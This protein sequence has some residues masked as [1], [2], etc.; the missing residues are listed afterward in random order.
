V[1][2][3]TQDLNILKYLSVSHRRFNKSEGEIMVHAYKR[4]C[5]SLAANFIPSCCRSFALSLYSPAR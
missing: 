1:F 4:L 5:F 3:A 2:I